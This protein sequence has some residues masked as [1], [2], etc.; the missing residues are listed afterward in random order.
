MIPQKKNPSHD[1]PESPGQTRTIQKNQLTPDPS[2]VWPTA[3]TCDGCVAAGTL[4][5]VEAAETLDAVRT[6]PLWGEGLAGQRS[7]AARAEKT[8]F[9]PHLVLVGH[10]SFSQSL[11]DT[12]R[13]FVVIPYQQ[14][15]EAGS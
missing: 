6:L 12:D 2:V 7:F 10:P 4:F 13:R 11:Q 3:L 15:G 5:G 9:V 1:L 14:F 8:L